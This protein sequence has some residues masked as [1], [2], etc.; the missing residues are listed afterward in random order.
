MNKLK[1]I[2]HDLKW[3]LMVE[4]YKKFIEPNSKILDVGAGE[5]Y[6]SKLMQDYF[7]GKVIGV[8][9]IDY[10]TNLVEHR[11]IKDNELPFPDKSF[12]VV[13]F[14][15]VL[16]HIDVKGQ[17]KILKE[18]KRVSKKI[19]IFED[20]KNLTSYFLDFI[21]N[22]PSMP[23]ALSHKNIR[24]WLGFMHNLGFKTSY[25]KVKRPFYYPL[26]HYIFVADFEK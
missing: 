5:L 15:N 6:I 24:E 26:K 17:K 3:K 19:I 9:V 25:H 2:M 10:G 16:H 8:D 1:K 22:R 18:A 11:T 7:K 23:K 13:T 21:T 14:N 12:D 20:A 4:H